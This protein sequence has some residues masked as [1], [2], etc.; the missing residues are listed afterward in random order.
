MSKDGSYKQQINALLNIESW[1]DSIVRSWLFFKDPDGSDNLSLISFNLNKKFV[2]TTSH[3]ITGIIPPEDSFY[4][5][6]WRCDKS[7]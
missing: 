2:M 3:D 5:D 4:I 6:A 1:K 7:L